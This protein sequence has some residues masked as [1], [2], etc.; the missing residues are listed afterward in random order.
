M[1]L[2]TRKLDEVRAH[3]RMKSTSLSHLLAYSRLPCEPPQPLPTHAIYKNY[4]GDVIQ[5]E[6][7]AIEGSRGEAQ[8]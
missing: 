5:I 7:I 2:R 6:Y 1:G 8:K 3:R 4:E